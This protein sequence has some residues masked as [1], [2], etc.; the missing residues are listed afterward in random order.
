M[1]AKRA[2]LWEFSKRVVVSVAI[3]F[4]AVVIYCAVHAWAY[5]D[6][7][8]TDRI[9]ESMTDVFKCTVITYG[10][11]AGIENAIKIA[12]NRRCEDEE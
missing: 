9:L 4:F 1:K 8:A 2:W 12:K 10:V 11:K 3:L 6:S 5:P 7:V